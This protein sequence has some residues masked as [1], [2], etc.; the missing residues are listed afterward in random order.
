MLTWRRNIK[1]NHTYQRTVG[2][3]WGY[4]WNWVEWF[5]SPTVVSVEATSHTQTRSTQV[6]PSEMEDSHRSPPPVCLAEIYSADLRRDAELRFLKVL[7]TTWFICLVLHKPFR[8]STKSSAPQEQSQGFPSSLILVDVRDLK[9]WGDTRVILFSDKSNSAKTVWELKV[10][11]SIALIPFLLRLS[12]LRLT[13]P[14]NMDWFRTSIRFA[15]R[16]SSLRMSGRPNQFQSISVSKFWFKLRFVRFWKELKAPSATA[17]TPA[18]SILSLVTEVRLSLHN[19]VEL[20]SPTSCRIITR[21][22]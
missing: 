9:T 13:S 20:I 3:L 1:E 14:V 22:E 15:A 6:D 18:F 11:W 16:L 12:L 4:H 10:L 5:V 19:T 21:D 17:V 8:K 7:K 2:W